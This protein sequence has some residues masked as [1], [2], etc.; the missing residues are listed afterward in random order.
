VAR[1]FPLQHDFYITRLFV[2]E[3]RPWLWA[4]LLTPATWTALDG[5]TQPATLEEAGRLL[6]AEESSDGKDVR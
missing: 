5:E 2:T 1:S 3:T 6:P 4:V